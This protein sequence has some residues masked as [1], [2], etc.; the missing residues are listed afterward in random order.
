MV[1]VQITGPVAEPANKKRFQ[2]LAVIV[3]GISLLAVLAQLGRYPLA[4]FDEATY[5][6]IAS[7]T[8]THGDWFAFQWHGAAWFEKPPL[9]L[10]LVMVSIKIM[11]TSEFSVR[12][13]SALFAVVA[14]LFL[15]LLLWEMSGKVWLSFLGGLA[16][17][18]VQPFYVFARQSRM[19]IPVIAA[20]LAAMWFFVKGQK[21]SQRKWILGVGIS[22]GVGVMIKSVIG[23]LSF[24]PIMVWSI[25]YK[26][27][28]WLK[29]KYLWIGLVIGL[30]VILPWHIYESMRFGTGFWRD[31]LLRQVL[32][33][34]LEGLGGGSFTAQDYFRNLWNLVQPWSAVFLLTAVTLPFAGKSDPK[35]RIAWFGFWSALAMFLLFLV[36]RTKIWTYLLPIFPFAIIFIS[37]GIYCILSSW[38]G[39]VRST[40]WFLVFGAILSVAAY[41]TW[42]NAFRDLPRYFAYLEEEKTIGLVLESGFAGKR[43]FVYD[44]QAYN[45]ISFYSERPVVYADSLASLPGDPLTLVLPTPGLEDLIREKPLHRPARLI[46]KGKYLSL[47]DLEQK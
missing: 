6:Q 18:A 2:I 17:L 45:T 46:Y 36:A 42:S 27:W 15:Y 29:N 37:V 14:V 8:L 38:L 3:V 35:R 10:W 7:E 26:K 28:D 1:E 21:Q 5:G 4:D 19:D 31:Y 11:G 16:I 39:R 34:G 25:V 13:P 43:S 20:I 9:Y 41:N 40:V 24:L 32:N 47:L 30:V 44:W 23:L 12:F 33:R 22:I